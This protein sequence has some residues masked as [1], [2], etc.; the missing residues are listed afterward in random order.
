MENTGGQNRTMLCKLAMRLYR[1]EPPM[2]CVCCT[3]DLYVYDINFTYN[4]GKIDENIPVIAQLILK[5]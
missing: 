4:N 5:A 2:K 3:S 1:Q